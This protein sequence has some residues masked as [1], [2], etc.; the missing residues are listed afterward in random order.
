M[1]D[2]GTILR[3]VPVAGAGARR[4]PATVRPTLR[5]RLRWLGQDLAL[6]AFRG[7]LPAGSGGCLVQVANPAR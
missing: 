4:R 1:T 6:L 7:R 2:A 3:A 5:L